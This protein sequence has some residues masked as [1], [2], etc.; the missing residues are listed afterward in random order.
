MPVLTI[1]GCRSGEAPLT[2][3]QGA[4]LRILDMLGEEDHT[5]NLGAWSALPRGTSV[6]DALAWITRLV[7]AYDALT[8][9]EA[10]DDVI[11]AYEM[12]GEP[13]P[14]DH[15]APVR[16]V[17]PG[18]IGIA[19]IKWVGRIEVSTEPL[20]SAWNTTQYRF[21]GPEHPEPTVLTTQVG[22]EAWV[23]FAEIARTELLV[24]DEGT[25]SRGFANEIRWNQAYHRL[26][27]GF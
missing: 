6:A 8:G 7:G 24:I 19:N 18:W 20:F 22:V 4:I 3:G 2:W 15:G 21:T 26:A 23:D 11:L 25:T 5:A 9:W 10:L 14:P 13:L 12:N 1:A 27:Q 16:L 17:V